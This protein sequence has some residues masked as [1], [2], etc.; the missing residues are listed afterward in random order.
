LQ[1]RRPVG[2]EPAG[3]E[4][5]QFLFASLVREFYGLDAHGLTRWTRNRLLDEFDVGLAP[6]ATE[7]S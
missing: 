2:E 5:S 3:E 1:V 7:N 4:A 6:R